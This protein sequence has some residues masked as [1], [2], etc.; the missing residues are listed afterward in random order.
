MAMRTLKQPGP[1]HPERITWFRGQ[2]QPLWFALPAGA[3]LNQAL[4]EPLAAAGLQ[5][6]T[7]VL[8][9]VA[10]S[11]FRYVMPGPADDASHVAWFSAPRA[12]DGISRIERANAT[13]GWAGGKPLV[14]CH[15]AW[16]GPDGRRRGGHIL[17]QE[18]IIA[19]PGEATAWG[20]ADIRIQAEA[21]EE[22]NFT[23]FQP[24]GRSMPGAAGIVARIRPNEDVVSAV[25]TICGSNG[26]RDAAV[27]GSL[28]S[29]IGARFTD[30]SRID[31]HATEV[32]VRQGRVRAG[33]AALE[34]L[35]VDMQ[36]T[37]HQ[38]WLQRGENPVCIT[39]DL[40]LEVAA[41]GA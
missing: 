38:G 22:T 21:D 13:F 37:V 19:E 35:V 18:T 29:L 32:L 24:S 2:P 39:F 34:L 40:V 10:L 5:S 16:T 1:V 4:S 17:P 28:G 30:G 15:A 7:L 14:H 11:P 25:E 36:G 31:D 6:A 33:E 26:I 41:A 20:F 3:T 23:L 12:P 8:T 9:D 27:R